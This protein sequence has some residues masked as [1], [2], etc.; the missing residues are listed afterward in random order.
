MS[1][2]GIYARLAA[3][4]RVC[5]G[6]P[7]EELEGLPAGILAA[8][9]G[10]PKPLTPAMEA[11]LTA[12][13]DYQK[14]FGRP[15]SLKELGELLNTASR[16]QVVAIVDGLAERGK[17]IREPRKHRSITIVENEK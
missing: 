5:E 6:V 12:I 13:R 11:A 16:R 2:R 1:T 10:N 14:R 7:T 3:C 4:A 9:L 8:F 17:I 15:V